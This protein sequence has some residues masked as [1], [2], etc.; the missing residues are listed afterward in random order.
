MHIHDFASNTY[1]QRTGA[2]LRVPLGR[3]Y[4][5]ALGD[6]DSGQPLSHSLIFILGFFWKGRLP[7]KGTLKGK[8]QCTPAYHRVPRLLK[9][10]EITGLRAQVYETVLAKANMHSHRGVFCNGLQA[11]CCS[12]KSCRGGL[13]V[14]SISLMGCTV[15]PAYTCSLGST[16]AWGRRYQRR[17]QKCKRVLKGLCYLYILSLWRG[18]ILLSRPLCCSGDDPTPWLQGAT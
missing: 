6:T 4:S 5:L 15:L 2:G 3:C 10:L 9:A 12:T 18:I 1:K 16:L 7:D 14:Y 17:K 13:L 11:H 8:N